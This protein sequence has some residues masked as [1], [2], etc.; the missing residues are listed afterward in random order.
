[1]PRNVQ[2]MLINQFVYTFVANNI[3]VSIVSIRRR[4]RNVVR[5]ATNLYMICV[6]VYAYCL[7]DMC[8]LSA[9]HST[10]TL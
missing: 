8:M 6:F 10:T 3:L 4:R 1:M 5:A 2:I 9:C 7:F